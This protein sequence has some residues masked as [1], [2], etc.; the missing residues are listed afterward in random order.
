MK[1][2]VLIFV[3]AFVAISNAALAGPGKC[4]SLGSGSCECCSSCE[5]DSAGDETSCSGCYNV[6]CSGYAAPT[7]RVL[8]VCKDKTLVTLKPDGSV[9]SAKACSASQ[10]CKME[11]N[12]N[13]KLLYTVASCH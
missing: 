10:S 2:L 7:V 11:T 5:Y 13:K 6:T 8:S 1:K 4:R 9:A 12:S 3:T